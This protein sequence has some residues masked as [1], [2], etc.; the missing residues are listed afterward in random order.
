MKLVIAVVHDEDK[1]KLANALIK[2]NYRFTRIASTGGFLKEGNV[3]FLLGI[4]DEDLERALEVI[5]A[6]C[7]TREQFVTVFPAG[8]EP[9]AVPLAYPFKITVGGAIVFVLNVERF[10]TI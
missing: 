5:G 9:V 10:E 3:T 2:E 1:D 7:K 6:T 4:D 8:A